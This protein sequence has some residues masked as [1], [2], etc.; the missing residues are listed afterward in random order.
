VGGIAYA[1][2]LDENVS[3]VTAE[4]PAKRNDT[5][6]TIEGLASVRKAGCAGGLRNTDIAVAAPLLVKMFHAQVEVRPLVQM[7]NLLRRLHRHPVNAALPTPLIERSCIAVLLIRL[8]LA[9]HVARTLIPTIS[10]ASIQLIFFA[11]PSGS[12][13]CSFII[14]SISEAGIVCPGSTFLG[15]PTSNRGPDNSHVSDRLG[16]PGCLGVQSVIGYM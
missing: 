15:L 10:A 16:L 4:A 3:P 11:S 2:A 12:P 13:S 5:I 9:L 14:R 8:P 1:A 7:Q 6:I